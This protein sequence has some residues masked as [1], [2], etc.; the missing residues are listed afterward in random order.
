MGN[1]KLLGRGWRVLRDKVQV[2]LKVSSPA[3]GRDGFEAG[4]AAIRMGM[5]DMWKCEEMQSPGARKRGDRLPDIVVV[6]DLRSR[7]APGI[8]WINNGLDL[9]SANGQVVPL[10]PVRFGNRLGKYF[11]IANKASGRG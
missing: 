9:A 11:M 10:E 7:P 6:T 3:Q 5:C 4:P 2:F 1:S 8:C